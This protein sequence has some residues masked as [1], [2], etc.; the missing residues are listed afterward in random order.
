MLDAFCILTAKLNAF[1]HRALFFAQ[2]RIGEQPKWFDNRVNLYYKWLKT[3]NPYWLERGA[4]S[5]LAMK[6]GAKV[7][8]LGCGDGFNSR[9]FYS[10]KAK[11]IVCVDFSQEALKTARRINKLNNIEFVF[12]DITHSL[13]NGKFDN[14]ILDSV[15]QQIK[16]E[17]I[18]SLL[19]NVKKH[20]ENN[21]ILSG[22][23][24]IISDEISFA[25]KKDVFDLFK[26]Y[27]KNVMIFETNCDERHNFYFFASDGILPFSSNWENW[28][29]N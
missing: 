16:K 24:H 7:L 17:K 4:Y 10:H 25:S 11:K 1:S 12:G 20:L 27:F 22:N 6:Q 8:E 9:N 15:I 2:W 23:T 29:K 5:L 18:D 14:I 3:R 26:P 28:T 21:G 13:P 19:K